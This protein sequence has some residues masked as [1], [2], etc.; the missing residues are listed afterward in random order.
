[1]C[2]LRARSAIWTT[3]AARAK[4]NCWTLES[5]HF[6]AAVVVGLSTPSSRLTSLGTNVET[7]TSSADDDAVERVT[8]EDV[9]QLINTAL[10]KLEDGQTDS[11][12]LSFSS[13]SSSTPSTVSTTTTSAIDTTV[14]RATTSSSHEASATPKLVIFERTT[15]PSLPE[16]DVTAGDDDH[17]TDDEGEVKWATTEAAADVVRTEYV[18]RQPIAITVA[19]SGPIQSQLDAAQSTQ[20][21]PVDEQTPPSINQDSST[22][23]E[24]EEQPPPPPSDSDVIA[25]QKAHTTETFETQSASSLPLDQPDT[26]IATSKEEATKSNAH[27]IGDETTAAMPA[28]EEEDTLATA[29]ATSDEVLSTARSTTTVRRLTSTKSSRHT[30]L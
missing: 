22:T 10:H 23:P 20:P 14:E 15:T 17:D 12:P 26:T 1:M 18:E 7:T 19:T 28:A 4:I 24:I 5:C 9:E 6:Q 16:A 29:T 13:F 8:Q 30:F 2:A 27:A 11:D 3:A 21:A 25:A